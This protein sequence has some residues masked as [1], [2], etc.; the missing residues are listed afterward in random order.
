MSLRVLFPGGFDLLHHGHI[1]ALK[2][3]RHIAGDGTLIVGVNS[4]TFMEHYKR[5]PAR[6]VRERI[7][8]VIDTGIADLVI[9]WDGPVKQGEQI[10][11]LKPDVYVAG[12][13]WLGK[14]LTAQLGLD[15]LEWF[16]THRISLLFLRRTEN[17]STSQLIR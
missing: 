12:T 6:T 15:S 14:N 16:D 8:D 1:Q 4:D 7:R 3:A 9:V 5:T 17:I 13:D 10:L 2:T 11:A